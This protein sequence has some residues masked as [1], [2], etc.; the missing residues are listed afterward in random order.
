VTGTLPTTLQPTAGTARRQPAPEPAEGF[1]LLEVLVVLVLLGI[2]T[3]FAVISLHVADPEQR[4]AREAHR[5]QAVL[6]LAAEQAVMQSRTLGLN[7]GD[8][9]Y[10]FLQRD[11][12][13]WRPLHDPALRARHVPTD[14]RLHLSAAPRHE[15][16]SAAPQVLLLA[17]GEL[18][19]FALHVRS[20]DTPA[21]VRILG[22]ETGE[23]TI[24]HRQ[25]NAPPAT[26]VEH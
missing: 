4:L 16:E 6:K 7:V 18:T 20:L 21:E 5:L 3:G 2:I 22:A 23:I 13:G 19:P 24:E 10:V 17:S 11:H 15:R 26:A 8:D 14:I 1:T 9:G 12:G 25:R